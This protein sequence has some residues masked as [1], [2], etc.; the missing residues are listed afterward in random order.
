MLSEL[1]RRDVHG[2]HT[3]AAYV[4][5]SEKVTKL[6][7]ERHLASS[8]AIGQY[9]PTGGKIQVGVLDFDSHEGA[10]TRE[11]MV[12]TALKVRDEAAKF[13]LKAHAFRSGGGRGIHLWFVWDAPQ[14]ARYVRHLLRNVLAAVELRDGTGGVVKGEV[15]VFP[16]QDRVEPG[17]FGSL[18]ALPGAR[19]CAPLDPHT[20]EP[21]EWEVLDFPS[22]FLRRSDPVPELAPEEQRPA[23]FERLHGDDEEV[24]AALKHIP[25]SDYQTWFKV[26]CA[27]KHSLGDEGLPIFDAWSATCG[28]KYPG[29]D[30]IRRRWNGLVPNGQIG[31]GSIFYL[32]RQYGWN[33]P[34]NP[35]I[36]EMNARF[37]ILTVGNATLII[38]KN[39]DRRPDDELITLSK[40]TFIDRLAPETF[41][42]AGQDGTPRPVPKAQFWLTHR[43]AA[44]YYRLD[45]DPALP[46]GNNGTTWNMWTGF[47]VEPRAGDWSLLKSHIFENIS[48]GSER[49]C[50]WLLNWMADGVQNRGEV[51]GTAPVLIGMPGTGKGVLAHAY[52]RLWGPHSVTVT[53]P[54]HVLGRFSGHLIARRFVL[55]D[56]GTFGGNRREAGQLKTRITEPVVLLEKKGIDAIRM[57][58]RM[59]FMLA[60][61]EASV[62]PADKND[63][64]WMIFEVGDNHREDR[65]YFAAIQR[66][67]EDGGY[68]AMLH[69]LLQRDISEE[70]DPR[71]VIKTAALFDQIIQA[72]G[73]EIGYIHMILEHGR[74]PQN[75]VDGPAVTSIRALVEEL[76]RSFPSS[77]G[78]VTEIALGKTL[79]RVLKSVRTQPAGRYFVK[80]GEAG[81]VLQRSTRYA[82]GALSSVRRE[83]AQY[84]GVPIGWN[85]DIEDWQRD[86]EPEWY[87][88]SGVI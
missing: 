82:F 6:V 11:T 9:F 23:A 86:P 61:N 50:D 38:V 41:T 13:G 77:S 85:E 1:L 60:S 80:M 39:G 26:M 18:I 67:L 21:V 25:A 12:S 71:R 52:A 64:R 44:H 73:P 48:A 74:L 40:A 36:R 33:G 27:L 34:S 70:P 43:L 81:A 78:Y 22:I 76:R 88:D 56:E 63:R 72:Q 51:I 17:K 66:Q 59:I 84:L 19:A 37:G 16:K 75:W 46:P 14:N 69:D 31:L 10:I 5:H 3:G 45:F 2:R 68:E 24:Q 28:E 49:H 20:L 32:A 4:L 8:P 58:N 83:F 47:G 65:P 79:K 55:I 35:I 42:I 29:P 15:E 54:E 53:H 87:D 7:L 30:E 62:V 57:K